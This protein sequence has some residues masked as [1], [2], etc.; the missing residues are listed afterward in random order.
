MKMSKYTVE[1]DI[2]QVDRIV[3]DELIRC[4]QSWVND[5]GAGSGVFVWGDQEAED[6]E[7]QK[8]ID[9][10]DVLLSWYCTDKQLE[11]YGLTRISTIFP[12]IDGNED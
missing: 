6:A 10:V 1:L 11:D 9:A 2:E 3:A 8:H 7:L 4:R 12:G 5:V